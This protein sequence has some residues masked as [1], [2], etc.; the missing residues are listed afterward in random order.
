MSGRTLVVTLSVVALLGAAAAVGGYFLGDSSGANLDS[1]RQEGIEAGRAEG[2][3]RG[4][5]RGY[6]EGLREGRQH[7]YQET[8][9][10]AY[11]EAYRKEYEDAGLTAPQKVSVQEP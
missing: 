2:A 8:Y 9:A 3:A 10:A 11:R 1:A 6:A 5:E 7:G 4:A